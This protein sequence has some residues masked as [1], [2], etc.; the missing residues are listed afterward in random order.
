MMEAKPNPIRIRL[1]ALCNTASDICK[2]NHK[3]SRRYPNVTWG[4]LSHP[5]CAVVGGG[6]SLVHALPLLRMWAGDIFAVNDTAGYLSD[7]GIPC[8]IFSLDCDSNPW[9]IG[10]LVKGAVFAT[11]VHRNQMKQ[12]KRKDVRV[13]RMAE[14][15]DSVDRGIEGGPTAA[16]R[17]PHLFLRMGYAQVHFFGAD[18]CFAAQSHVYGSYKN[19]YENMVIIRVND[20]DYISNAAFMLQAQY[21]LDVFKKHP[22][23]LINRSGGLLRAMQMH[24]D[25]WEVVAITEDLKKQYEA[26]G[27]DLWRR[28]YQPGERKIWQPPPQISSPPLT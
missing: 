12:F 25:T 20:V 6:P 8:Y 15:G 10:P 21:L 2:K 7:N 24:P 9:K 19:A 16:C 4:V 13:F 3:L 28:E 18:G 27:C 23:F 1:E 26:G 5:P 11:R 17:A 14:E 22:Q